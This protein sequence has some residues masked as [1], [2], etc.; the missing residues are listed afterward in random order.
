MTLYQAPLTHLQILGEPDAKGILL[1]LG[2]C[3]PEHDASL[4]SAANLSQ[5]PSVDIH[6]I[7]YITPNGAAVLHPGDVPIVETVLTDGLPV[8]LGDLARYVKTHDLFVLSLLHGGEGEDGTWAG[9]AQIHRINGSFGPV[10]PSSLGMNKWAASNLAVAAVHDLQQPSSVL[11]G[12]YN[13]KEQL[14]RASELFDGQPVVIKPNSMGASL[15]THLLTKWNHE[16]AEAYISEILLFADSA[17]VQQYVKGAEY[18]CGILDDGTGPEA[19]PVMRISTA[20][21]FYSHEEKHSAANRTTKDFVEDEVSARVQEAAIHLFQAFGLF[22]FARF[23]FI[24]D[25]NG[26]IHFLEVNGIPGL[27]SGSIYPAMLRRTGRGLNDLVQT[28]RLAASRKVGLKHEFRYEI[29]E[30]D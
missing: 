9:W 28:L 5:D 21:F 11:V 24:V 10:F 16:A 20:G 18:S 27:M 17:L 23:D 25:E 15:F 12:R 8:S 2:G 29:E 26:A 1:L 30:H 13:R 22:G 19:L 14:A 7:A 3:S 4:K 6:T